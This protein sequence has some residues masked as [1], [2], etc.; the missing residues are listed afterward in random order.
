MTIRAVSA[1]IVRKTP[2][3]ANVLGQIALACI[4]LTATPFYIYISA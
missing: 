3:V 4:L 1:K 2:S